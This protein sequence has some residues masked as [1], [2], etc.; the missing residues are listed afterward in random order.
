MG[1]S[2]A[3]HTVSKLAG[4]FAKLRKANARLA[5]FEAASQRVAVSAEHSAFAVIDEWV[6]LCMAQVEQFESNTVPDLINERLMELRLLPSEVGALSQAFDCNSLQLAGIIEGH[7]YE[8][9][10]LSLLVR[11]SRWSYSVRSGSSADGD[12]I[13]LRAH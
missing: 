13:L 7:I 3:T 6:T 8:R 4:A 5:R 2:A 10:D 11:C 1:T 9:F 12:Y